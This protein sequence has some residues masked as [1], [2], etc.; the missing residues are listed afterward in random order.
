MREV[1]DA[2]LMLEYA[3]GD[4]DAFETLYRRHRTALYRYVL[5]L[6]G[7][8]ATAND[9]YQGTWER[10]IRARSSYQPASPFAAWMYRIAH[11]HIVDHWRRQ[12]SVTSTD[13]V[14]LATEDAGPAE[15]AT[16]EERRKHLA[17]AIGELPEEQ[18]VALML[19][20]EADLGLEEIAGITGVGRET[21]KSRLR[22][23][24]GKLKQVLQ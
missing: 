16:S 4:A 18:R 7:D 24:V 15:L 9:L 6:V 22:Y 23:A 1:N 13:K 10:I 21:V 2:Q 8:E 20:L 3:A 5:R 14:T 12:R 19:R 11:N 17:E